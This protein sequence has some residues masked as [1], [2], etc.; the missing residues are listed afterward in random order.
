M[1]GDLYTSLCGALTQAVRD[2]RPLAA[3]MDTQALAAELEHRISTYRGPGHGLSWT[4]LT[5]T[6]RDVQTSIHQPAAG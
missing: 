5:A 4:E 6:A 1:S 2:L 3:G